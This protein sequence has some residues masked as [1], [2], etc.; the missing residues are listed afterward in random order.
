MSQS[1]ITNA[2]SPWLAAR[3]ADSKPARPD[4]MV[5]AWIEAQDESAEI[6]PDEQLPAQSL[7]THTADIVHF[8]TL[9]ERAFVCSVVLD[10][11]V[12]NW[13]YN[14]IGLVD[15]ESDTLLMIVHT[16]EQQKIKTA[17]GIQGNTLSR[18]LMMEFSG[19]AAASQITVTAETWQIDYSARLRSM[20]ESRRVVRIDYYGEA[21]FRDNGFL[22]T[23]TGGVLHATPGLGY[24]AGLRVELSEATA[25]AAV[26]DTGV[27]VDVVWSGTVT[28][29]W[30]YTFTMRTGEGL[31]DYTDAAGFQHY[32]AQIAD[33]RNGT[34]T[35]LRQPFPLQRLERVVDELDVHSREEA[36]NRFLQKDNNLS[37]IP[38]AAAA[39][40][41]LDVYNRSEAVPA[42]RKINSK[43][44]NVDI[45]LNADDVDAVPT[46][47]TING[48]ALTQD[49]IISAASL[50]AV[51]GLRA[52]AASSYQERGLAEY[53]PGFM[54][55]WAD[56]GTSNYW[57]QVRPIQYQINDVWYNVE[58][59]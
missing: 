3:L 11:T 55:T 53:P 26:S 36:D 7:I 32:V 34:V 44:L 38:D 42:V 58:F 54:T 8:G 49:L 21:A 33:V 29:A 47:R 13:R 19:A 43:Q 30:A 5:F 22:I 20:D 10:T 56:K 59:M 24:V 23:A 45:T 17:A 40:E 25:V 41:A 39:R 4:R 52:G 28:G 51:T 2:F 15:S 27:W 1:V 35:D 46:S 18:N 50:F 14:W 57:I 37:D 9:N 6:N 16:A 12:G 31:T 48:Q